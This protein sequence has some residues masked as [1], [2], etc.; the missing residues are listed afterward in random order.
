[1]NC[2]TVAQLVVFWVAISQ[3]AGVQP[4]SPD[5]SEQARGAIPGV[6]RRMRSDD[7]GVRA[8]L[9]DELVVTERD[10]DVA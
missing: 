6:L 2:L 4:A 5:L 3:P 9:I 10:D 1:M 8:A 7:A